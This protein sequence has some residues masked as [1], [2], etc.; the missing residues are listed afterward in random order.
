MRME[1][2]FVIEDFHRHQGFTEAI[3]TLSNTEKVRLMKNNLD[4]N[5][6]TELTQVQC[7]LFYAAIS[8]IEW[9]IVLENI[10]VQE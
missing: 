1:T 5:E 2:K 7:N 4:L 3:N 6:D 9:D 8:N 10:E